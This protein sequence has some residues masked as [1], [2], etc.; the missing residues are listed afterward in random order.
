[1]I[2]KTMYQVH[3]YRRLQHYNEEVPQGISGPFE[4]RNTAERCAIALAQSGQ[5]S[6]AEIKTII[7]EES[8]T[9]EHPTSESCD[10]CTVPSHV[11]GIPEPLTGVPKGGRA[12]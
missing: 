3:A 2:R 7:V 10:G 11:P 5:C 9:C 4:A 1:M 12:S 8:E 6:R